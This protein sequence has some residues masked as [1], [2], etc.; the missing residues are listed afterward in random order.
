[1]QDTQIFTDYAAVVFLSDYYKEFVDG[2]LI[3]ID[4]NNTKLKD[5]VVEPKIGRVVVYTSGPEN[6][7]VIKKVTAGVR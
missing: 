4:V 7:F 2:R 1:M 5:V 3:F 6:T